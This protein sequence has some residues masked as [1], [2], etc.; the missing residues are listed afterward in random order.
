MDTTVVFVLQMVWFA[1][2]WSVLARFVVWPWSQRLAPN[3]AVAVWV[4]PQMFRAL[5]LGLLVPSLSPGMPSAFAFPTAAGDSLTAVLGLVAFVALQRDHR[6]GYPLAWACTLTG[7]ADGLHAM[8]LAARL[9]AAEHMT[10]Q[11]YVP[12]LGLPLMGVC[13]VACIVALL[14]ARARQKS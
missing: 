8:F 1:T 12:A 13:H 7:S 5:G 4:A 9:G 2:A 14:R 10:A 6:F 11:W 3:H